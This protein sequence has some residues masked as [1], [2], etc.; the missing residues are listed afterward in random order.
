M[1]TDKLD[2]QILLVAQKSNGKWY[3]YAKKEPDMLLRSF[4]YTH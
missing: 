2:L 3:S 4:F 1:C